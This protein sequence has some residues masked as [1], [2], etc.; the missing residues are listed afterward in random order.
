MNS[1]KRKLSKKQNQ[2]FL[3]KKSLDSALQDSKV[4][5]NSESDQQEI[6]IHNSNNDQVEQQH[7]DD[8]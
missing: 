2:Q 8:N 4:G 1:L 6:P 5:A 3:H 7:E